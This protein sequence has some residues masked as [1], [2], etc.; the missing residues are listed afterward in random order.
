[1][2]KS[3][4]LLFLFLSGFTEE[5]LAVTNDKSFQN[6]RKALPKSRVKSSFH[7]IGGVPDF[8]FV[9]GCS[10]FIHSEFFSFSL[11]LSTHLDLRVSLYLSYPLCSHKVGTSSFRPTEYF[12]TINIIAR[13]EGDCPAALRTNFGMIFGFPRCNLY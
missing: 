7:H 6:V 3:H 1:M 5:I 10:C 11:S 8:V 4:S 9:H 2:P 12:A 13:N